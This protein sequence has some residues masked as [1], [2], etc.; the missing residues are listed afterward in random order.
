VRL[1]DFPTHPGTREHTLI[2]T[3]WGRWLCSFG[4]SDFFTG[5]FETP[6]HSARS[7][8]GSVRGL[9]SYLQ[10]FPW[11]NPEIFAVVEGGRSVRLHVHALVGWSAGKKGF[12]APPKVRRR[13]IWDYWHSRH[14]RARCEPVTRGRVL[15]AAKY[16]VKSADLTGA[17]LFLTSDDWQPIVSE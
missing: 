1:E 13:E 3:A 12:A 17:S 4:W 5:T 9:R 10:R 6:R 7:C 15:Y 14:G 8:M 11:G 16:V 2:Q